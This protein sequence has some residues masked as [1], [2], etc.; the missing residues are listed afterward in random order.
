MVA[1]VDRQLLGKAET[2]WVVHLIET[3]EGMTAGIAGA[4]VTGLFLWWLG[5]RQHGGNGG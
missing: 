5:S 3:F 4:V 2:R 1:D